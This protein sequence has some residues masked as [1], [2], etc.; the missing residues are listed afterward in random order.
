MEARRY[1]VSGMVQ[2]VGFRWFVQREARRLEMSGYVKNLHDGRVEV[3]A[4]GATEKLAA[5]RQLLERGPV[6]A[7][8]TEVSEQE[9][10]PGQ[11]DRAGFGIEF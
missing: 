3:L 5:L 9:A 1:L 6:G 11:C 8:V 2:G 7:R 4:V 10:A